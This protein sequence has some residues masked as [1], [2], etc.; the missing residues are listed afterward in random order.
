MAIIDQFISNISKVNR[1]YDQFDGTSLIEL[2][3]GDNLGDNEGFLMFLVWSITSPKVTT[4]KH[5][6]LVN[7]E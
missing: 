1:F 6:H 4:N 2:F 3:E 7:N 5:G